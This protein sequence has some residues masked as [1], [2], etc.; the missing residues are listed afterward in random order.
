[1]RRTTPVSTTLSYFIVY[2]LV[3]PFGGEIKV[4]TIHMIGG[5]GSIL[6]ISFANRIFV[7]CLP[8]ELDA[9]YNI[10]VLTHA[11]GQIGVIDI[12]DKG[13]VMLQDIDI[14]GVDKGHGLIDISGNVQVGGTGCNVNVGAVLVHL[15]EICNVL[16]QACHFIGELESLF[17]WN[18]IDSNVNGGHSETNPSSIGERQLS[19]RSFEWTGGRE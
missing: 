18:A 19:L 7:D 14:F 2:L 12:S 11:L 15:L 4:E 17:F 1:M 3:G 13:K 5:C 9:P 8:I 10:G 6:G 16:S